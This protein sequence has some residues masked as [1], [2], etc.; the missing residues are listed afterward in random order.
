MISKDYHKNS[1]PTTHKGSLIRSFLEK[2]WHVF[3]DYCGWDYQYEPYPLP[4]WLPD[5]VLIGK[6]KT[7][8]V[9]V[10]PVSLMIDL[11]QFFDKISKAVGQADFECIFLGCSIKKNRIGWMVTPSTGVIKDVVFGKTSDE[12]YDI[13]IPNREGSMEGFFTGGIVTPEDCTHI[14]NYS[15]NQVQWRKNELLDKYREELPLQEL[16]SGCPTKPLPR[17]TDKRPNKLYASPV[18]KK[19]SGKFCAGPGLNWD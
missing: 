4:T 14:W 9:E 19:N 8:L 13:I 3:F 1:R 7:Y 18:S 11:P 17:F 16:P 12:K 5:F 10:K 15:G 6:S 2:K